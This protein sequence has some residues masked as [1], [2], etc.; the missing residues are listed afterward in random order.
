[1]GFFRNSSVLFLDLDLILYQ[2]FWLFHLEYF[3]SE[4]GLWKGNVIFYCLKPTKCYFFYGP[5]PQIYFQPTIK[6]RMST[7]QVFTNYKQNLDST[8]D[9]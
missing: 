5:R 3:I 4:D 7:E 6:N 9:F 8:C 2:L 1:M